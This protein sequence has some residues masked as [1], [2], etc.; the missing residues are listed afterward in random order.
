M[1]VT[2]VSSD[3]GAYSSRAARTTAV[4]VC[5]LEGAVES[6]GAARLA[7]RDPDDTATEVAEGEAEVLGTEVVGV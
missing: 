3:D 4:V 1:G 5:F 2:A 6:D 7:R